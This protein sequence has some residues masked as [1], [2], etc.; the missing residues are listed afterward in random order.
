MKE[1]ASWENEHHLGAFFE[2]VTYILLTKLGIPIR[3]KE[4]YN[5]YPDFYIDIP[6]APGIFFGSHARGR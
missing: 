4:R 3:P 6:M 5:D 1:L 2:L